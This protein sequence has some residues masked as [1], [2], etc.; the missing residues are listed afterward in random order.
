MA[1]VL[2]FE[3]VRKA[4]RG[5]GGER[6]EVLKGVDWA[7]EEG[8]YAVVT[9]P[10]GCGKSTLLALAALLEEPDEGRIFFAGREVA[11]A[12]E[13]ER[14][15]IRK[16]GIGMVFQRFHLLNGRSALEN[17]ELRFRYLGTP[18]REVREKSL[19]A[20]E[21]VGMADKA[22]RDVRVLSSGEQQ[23]VAIA[24]A[25]AEPPRLLLAD[26]PTGNL[27]EETAARIMDLF[28]ELNAGGLSLAVVTHHPA[29]RA[30]RARRWRL[31]GGVMAL[32]E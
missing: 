9:G 5:R 31:H 29:W 2:R 23:R 6:V 24:R 18:R 32:A 13:A 14:T 15:E 3:G 1:D 22:G 28:G 19:A 11:G 7:V 17:V 27:D 21:R 26:E 10:S 12:G 30:P 20:L 8:G 4:F 16:R 25:I